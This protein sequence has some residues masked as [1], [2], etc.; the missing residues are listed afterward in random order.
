MDARTVAP[1]L[2]RHAGLENYRRLEKF[3]TTLD[4]YQEY[5]EAALADYARKDAA[6]RELLY[7]AVKDRKVESVLDVGCGAG[8]ELLPFAEKTTAMCIGV[9]AAPEVGATGKAV[10]ARAGFDCRVEFISSLGESLPFAD[11][12]FDVVICRVALPYMDNRRALAEFSRV[13]CSGGVLLLKIHA[14]AFYFEMIRQRA[15][16]LSLKQIAYPLI[17][18]TGSGAYHLTGRQPNKGFWRGK[19]IFQTRA[20]LKKELAGHDLV[21]ERELPDTNNQTPSFL[22]VKK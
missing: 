5:A 10:F 9:D 6:S 11:C 20:T 7:S 8:Q 14:P 2:H 3:M 21:I 1:A 4:T 16:S 15:G 12:S 18:L 13:L 19:E 22:I 17:C